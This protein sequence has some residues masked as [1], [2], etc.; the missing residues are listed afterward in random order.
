MV[1]GR[2]MKRRPV[3]AAQST[4]TVGQVAELVGVIPQRL[5]RWEFGGLLVPSVFTP[6][7]RAPRG[8]GY[9]R[10]Y[11]TRD[12]ALAWAI[13]ALRGQRLSQQKV[14][15][16]VR[17]LQRLHPGRHLAEVLAEPHTGI[18]LLRDSHNDVRQV[19]LL[20]GKPGET[21][22]LTEL[23]GQP[24]QGVLEV[25]PGLADDLRRAMHDVLTGAADVREVAPRL[26][27]AAGGRG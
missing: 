26:G 16:V 22:K 10:V 9:D 5:R 1:Y 19:V 14:G 18:A 8:R 7:G 15:G 25:V 24:G 2:G 3:F 21:R 6:A 11:D 4:Y 23:M 12:V 17:E 20:Q 13:K 27:A